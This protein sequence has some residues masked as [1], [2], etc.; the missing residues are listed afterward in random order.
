MIIFD[1]TYYWLVFLAFIIGRY[2]LIAGVAFWLLQSA[3]KLA[4]LNRSVLRSPRWRLIHHDIGL[5]ISSAVIFALVAALIMIA[6]QAGYTRLYSTIDDYGWGYLGLS[7]MVT[8]LFQDAYFYLTHRLIHHPRLFKPMHQGHH[9]SRTPTPWTS[10]A[11]DP[12]EAILHSLFFVG[13]VFILPLH[14]ATLLLA[15]FTMTLWAVATHLGVELIPA[16]IRLGWL[17]RGIIGP[18][19]HTMHHHQYRVHFGLYFTFWDWVCGTT[20]PTYIER[21]RRTE[22]LDSP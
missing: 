11:F 7:F 6:Y 15:F 9:Y 14:F 1:I 8:L 13:L 3:S 18:V 16:Q 22:N 17:R 5:S 19:H 10:F 4:K 21:Y 20:D 2:F 12:L